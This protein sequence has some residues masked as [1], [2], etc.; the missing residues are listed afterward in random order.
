MSE[1]DIFI[2]ALQ[3]ETPAER[4]AYLEAACGGKNGVR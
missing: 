1:R 2:A 4:Q 3:K